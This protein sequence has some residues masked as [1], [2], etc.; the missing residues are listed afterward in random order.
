MQGDERWWL[1]ICWLCQVWWAR[2]GTE[3][4][5]HG[6]HQIFRQNWC[7]IYLYNHIIYI[8]IIICTILLYF[9]FFFRCFSTADRLQTCWFV[10]VSVGV[11]RSTGP[12]TMAPGL[13]FDLLRPGGIIAGGYVRPLKSL[14]HPRPEQRDDRDGRFSGKSPIWLPT[15]ISTRFGTRITSIK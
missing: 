11:L 9:S 7:Y 1:H 13:P 4:E 12:G 15:P 2:S 5:S 14:D 6:S 3:K 8:Y 10:D